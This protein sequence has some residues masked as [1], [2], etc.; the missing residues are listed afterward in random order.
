M[1]LILQRYTQGPHC[2]QEAQYVDPTL[3]LEIHDGGAGPYLVVTA[4]EWA[5]SDAAEIDALA[6]AAK[7]LLLMA[8]AA[9]PPESV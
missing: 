9:E 3:T 6:E 5:C 7:R 2:C 8:Q 4:V 1:T